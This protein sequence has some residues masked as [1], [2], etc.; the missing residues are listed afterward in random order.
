MPVSMYNKSLRNR[1]VVF[2][3]LGSVLFA[4]DIRTSEIQKAA[5]NFIAGHAVLQSSPLR[6]QALPR[7]QSI[8]SYFIQDRQEP[9]GYIVE[10]SPDGFIV[11]T[12]TTETPPVIA[13]TLSSSWHE[14]TSINNPIG[15]LIHRSMHRFFKDR[16][17]NTNS[18]DQ[19]CQNDWRRL[20][21][22]S[23]DIT[24]S[25][26]LHQWPEQGTTSTGGWIETFFIQSWPFNQYCPIDP[27][28]G[29]RSAVGCVATAMAQ[30]IHYHQY[31]D[32]TAFSPEDRYIT[33]THSIHIDNDSTSADFP[34]F[35]Q[36]N[37][38]LNLLQEKYQNESGCDDTDYAVLSFACGLSV[39]MDFSS[40]GS[41]TG[42]NRS[43][44]AFLKQFGYADARYYYLDSEQ[45]RYDFCRLL[46]RDA[47]N[48]LPSIVSIGS[49]EGGHAVV[50]DGYNTDGFYH[51]NY[52]WGAAEPV[53]IHEAW[54][55]LPDTVGS[56]YDEITGGTVNIQPDSEKIESLFCADSLDLGVVEIGQSSEFMSFEITNTSHLSVEV[57]HI[58]VSP[59]FLVS[60]TPDFSVP[61][62][63]LM[64]EPHQSRSI[65]VRFQ[66]EG[67]GL[68][69]RDLVIVYDNQNR[70]LPCVLT[71]YGIPENSTAVQ[72]KAVKGTWIR[73]RSPY[74]IFCPIEIPENQSL[75]IEAGV[76]VLFTGPYSWHIGENAQLL[77]RGVSNDSIVICSADS[78]QRWQGI[79]FE[80]SGSD[81]SLFY[82][83]IQN[84]V[85]DQVSS[86]A[87]RVHQ[88]SPVFSHCGF[89]DN[90]SLWHAILDFSGSSTTLESCTFIR[91][92]AYYGTVY[93][94]DSDLKMDHSLMIENRTERHGLVTS[95]RSLLAFSHGTVT[96]NQAGRLFHMNSNSQMIIRNTIIWGNQ[97]EGF[98][99]EN[100][101]G[102]N[103]YD[104]DYSNIDTASTDWDHWYNSD[105][106]ILILGENNLF[107]DPQWVQNGTLP[108]Q[109]S[110]LSSC[111]DAG[112]PF[113]PVNEEPFPHGFRVNL[114]FY[115]GTE[116][117]QST[118]GPAL[119]IDPPTLDFGDRKRSDIQDG[120]LYLKNGGSE[121][122]QITHVHI[123]NGNHFQ[124]FNTGDANAFE[125]FS[126]D[127]QS[128]ETGSIRI[129]FHP[130]DNYS[131]RYQD[132]LIV[133]SDIPDT[134]YCLLQGGVRVGTDIAPGHLE[135]L[136]KKVNSPYHIYG[137]V[138]VPSGKTLIIEPGVICYFMGEYSLTVAPGGCMKA[139]GSVGDSIYFCSFD[140]PDTWRGI[141]VIHSR[142]ENTF[143]YCVFKRCSRPIYSD[144]TNE[145]NSPICGVGA[146]LIDQ[147][148]IDVRH[149][150][151]INNLGWSGGAIYSSDSDISIR[152]CRF[153]SNLANRG[154]AIY[155]HASSQSEARISVRNVLLYN[156]HAYE[157]GGGMYLNVYGKEFEITN[158]TLCRNS[159]AEHGGGICFSGTNAYVLRNS[160]LWQNKAG[161]GNEISVDGRNNTLTIQYTSLDTLSNNWVALYPDI[162]Y[163]GNPAAIALGEGNQA[164]NPVFT[165]S[166]HEDWTLQSTSPCIDSGHPDQKY[167]DTEDP[168]HPGLA[169]YP[170]AGTLRNDMGAFGG[171]TISESKYLLSYPGWQLIGCSVKQDSFQWKNDFSEGI[172]AYIW[173]SAVCQY[174]KA[175]TLGRSQGFWLRTE[176]PFETVVQGP[177]LYADSLHL[178]SGWHLVSGISRSLPAAC[179][180]IRPSQSVMAI[181]RWNAEQQMYVPAESI[182]PGQ[183]YWFAVA[184]ECDVVFDSKRVDYFYLPK[185]TT[186]FPTRFTDHYGNIP[187]PPPETVKQLSQPNQFYLWNNY[188]N[189][190]NSVT[191]I[192]YEIPQTCHVRIQIYNIL[193]KLITT[194]QEKK[195]DPG[196]YFIEWKGVDHQQQYVS[197][198]VYICRV[199]AGDETRVI[200]MVLMN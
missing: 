66:P 91:N 112:D 187:P 174:Q 75:T 99:D 96:D 141:N 151:F 79:L 146:L 122:L 175:D 69:T 94:F 100:T 111:I 189:P 49:D 19:D 184:R 109:L 196:K 181:Y 32:Q 115:G 29:N 74:F 42:T 89:Y 107:E 73:D 140:T 11:F 82:C 145:Y 114:G 92:Q 43:A 179:L 164:G 119:A 4:R 27:L 135:G 167:Q 149:S 83:Q 97:T 54:F 159:A 68:C 47:M 59:P 101:Y 86:G 117:A 129:R 177:P 65:Y 93:V 182:E 123:A 16:S 40:Y 170:A 30:I 128:G 102:L 124:I 70:F 193:G 178:M 26:P 87:L 183:G 120:V 25:E 48:G 162:Y 118:S 160:I 116:N 95:Y 195:Q 130:G 152:D 125:E 51:F 12:A 88:C 18:E 166:D 2:I 77:C 9:A 185:Y 144:C 57:N 23:P 153:K 33:L 76:E 104:L 36:L 131:L 142:T 67:T 154:G 7:V 197:S 81:D 199:K 143:S 165:D 155:I 80:N 52:G 22:R 180:Q 15:Y 5:E 31:F 53:S 105:R 3:L 148:A 127:L 38:K 158:A 171:G 192:F 55:Y 161:Q 39:E 21:G 139:E 156:N 44:D 200:K 126:V 134:A 98:Q 64:I 10:L 190:F 103:T 78:V 108:F 46:K 6:K 172:E 173:D 186:E 72:N 85:N 1:I 191:K 8:R 60:A 194:L 17:G 150:C 132:T 35:F 147:S 176:I 24:Q 37:Q 198:G 13:Y 84:I 61:I 137:D 168:E 20:S 41:S 163:G 56:T 58:Q 14:D 138:T 113:C 106:E 188:P 157:S 110:P 121:S 62:T 90:Q 34:S 45:S 63:S 136:L 71:G 28:T 169:L 50:C 133:I